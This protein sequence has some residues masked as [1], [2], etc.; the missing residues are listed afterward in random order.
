MTNG[1][2]LFVASVSIDGSEDQIQFVSFFPE[3]SRGLYTFLRRSHDHPEVKLGFTRFT[4]TKADAVFELLARPSI[5]GFT[6]VCADA[7]GGPH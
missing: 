2:W 4:A 6:V 1:N 7:S 3:W 5:V